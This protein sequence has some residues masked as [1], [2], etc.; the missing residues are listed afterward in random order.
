MN[1][2][3]GTLFAIKM[4]CVNKCPSYPEFIAYSSASSDFTKIN[5]GFIGYIYIF[6]IFIITVLP[7]MHG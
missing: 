3:I 1:I 5:H 6:T 4:T 2:L 7:Q